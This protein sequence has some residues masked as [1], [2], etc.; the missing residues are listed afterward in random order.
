MA[1]GEVVG[2]IP[3]SDVGEIRTEGSGETTIG[4][5]RFSWKRGDTLAAPGGHAIGH[6][7]TSDA[8]LFALTDEPLLLS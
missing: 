1:S 6:R 3:L 7:A 8:Q 2:R 4:D 5:R